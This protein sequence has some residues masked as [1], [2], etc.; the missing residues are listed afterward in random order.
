MLERGADVDFL[1]ISTECVDGYEFKGPAP[2]E[3]FNFKDL[4]CKPESPFD[5]YC[6]SV[7]RTKAAPLLF[8]W[9]MCLCERMLFLFT[10]IKSSKK[11]SQSVHLFRDPFPFGTY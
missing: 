11:V 10:L 5:S 7:A 4:F 9:Q 3:S 2:A 6:K 8:T 1:L